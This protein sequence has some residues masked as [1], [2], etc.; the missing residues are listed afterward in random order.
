[1]SKKHFLLPLVCLILCVWFTTCAA[2][3]DTEVVTGLWEQIRNTAWTKDGDTVA[4]VGFYSPNKGPIRKIDD[5]NYGLFGVNPNNPIPY[6][7]VGSIIDGYGHSRGFYPIRI[8]RTGN[9]ILWYY[10]SEFGDEYE[11]HFFDI[12]LSGNSITISGFSEIY[13]GMSQLFNG[14]YTKVSSDPDY[15][16]PDYNWYE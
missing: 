7:F 15:D 11:H 8:D 16:W 12:S 9:Q 1:M 10:Y 13:V 3:D 4:T 14:T 5:D 2:N 6:V